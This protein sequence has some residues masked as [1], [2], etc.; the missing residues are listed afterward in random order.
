MDAIIVS[1][2]QMNLENLDFIKLLYWRHISL[3]Y[4]F[5]IYKC[6]YFICY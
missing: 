1:A 4:R 2:I 5:I 6:I 3:I